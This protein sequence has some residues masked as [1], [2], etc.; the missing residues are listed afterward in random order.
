VKEIL[1]RPG[2]AASP[3]RSQHRNAATLNESFCRCWL[4]RVR[5]VTL[6][7]RPCRPPHYRR[8]C[9]R[10]AA[11]NEGAARR[12]YSPRRQKRAAAPEQV[13]HTLLLRQRWPFRPIS[14]SRSP[15]LSDS[16]AA[17]RHQRLYQS[18]VVILHAVDPGADG[19]R[20]HPLGRIWLQQRLQ[21]ISVRCLLAKPPSPCLQ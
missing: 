20:A 19:V 9:T 5:E 15:R 3:P 14:D 2:R 21:F 8:S 16:H 18:C 10:V 11:A 13:D 7:T 6:F 12:R 17:G 4:Q 1:R